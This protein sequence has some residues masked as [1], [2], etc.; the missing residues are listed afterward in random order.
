MRS[1]RL[2]LKLGAGAN[3]DLTLR[4]SL[5]SSV[6]R[7]EPW[8]ITIVGTEAGRNLGTYQ[9]LLPAMEVQASVSRL[10]MP[11]VPGAAPRRG[12]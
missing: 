12:S 5:P 8:A 7:S 6:C 4:I 9:Q 11:R 1:V 2:I 10:E 3:L